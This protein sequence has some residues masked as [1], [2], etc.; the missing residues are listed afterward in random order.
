MKRAICNTSDNKLRK[1]LG[2]NICF[3]FLAEFHLLYLNQ[4]HSFKTVPPLTSCCY[5]LMAVWQCQYVL[6]SVYLPHKEV[7]I[8]QRAVQLLHI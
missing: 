4:T 1:R 3:K 2:A 6:I 7:P 8:L 5:C